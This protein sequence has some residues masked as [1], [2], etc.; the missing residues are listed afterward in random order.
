MAR[1]AREGDAEEKGKVEEAAELLRGWL[2][3]GEVEKGELIGLARESGFS[4]STLDRAAADL[5]VVK[6]Q[7]GAGKDKRSYWSLPPSSPNLVSP[8]ISP[9]PGEIEMP[10]ENEE[11]QEL[12]PPPAAQNSQSHQRIING[13]NEAIWLLRLG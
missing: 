6:R 13:A 4:A 11:P 9:N 1:A 12:T 5:K 2:E 7:Q 8:S 10:D 3:G